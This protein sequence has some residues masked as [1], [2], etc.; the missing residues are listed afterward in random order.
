M[1]W[2]WTVA[3]GLI[4]AACVRPSIS[5][6][7]LARINGEP[8]T[9]EELNESFTSRH[10]GHGVLLAGRGA[11]RD[12][13]DTVIDR[14][15]L[16]QEALRIGA[17]EDPE[18]QR[19]RA[20]LRAKR[21]AEGFYADQVTKKVRVTDE[22]IAGVHQRLGDRFSARHILAE[23]RQDAARALERVRAGEEFGEVARQ[24][25]RADTASRGG[26]LGIVQWGRSEQKL[27]DVLWSLK[28][29]EISEPFETESG[30]NLL[31][32]VERT[33]VEPPKLAD[34]RQR[35]KANLEQRE[36]RERSTA[37]FRKLMKRPGGRIDEAPLVAALTARSG[38][39][40]PGATVVAEAAGEP[41]TLERALRLVKLEAAR[42][43]PPDRLRRQARWL[44]EAEVFRILLEKEG[45]ARGYG[46]RPMVVRELD[47]VTDQAAF[48]ALLGKVVLAKVEISDRDVS[49]YYRDHPK[50]YT[51]P[52]AVKLSA[53]LVEKE[54]EAK[55]LVSAL[56]QG[57]EFRVLARTAS[58]DPT[59]VASGGEIQGWI[60]RGKLDP[61]VEEVAF[62][63]KEGAVGIATGKAGHFVVRLDRRRAEQLKPFDEVKEHA[64]EAALR[65]RSRDTVKAWARKLRGASTI[66]VD[67][68]AIDRA[69]ASYEASAREK[70]AEKAERK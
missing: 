50:E 62:S 30:W 39:G 25:S 37:L 41:I 55:D 17:D 34:T 22:E 29:G 44:L 38:E 51:E 43:L 61:A 63:L 24:M 6:L 69:I 36:S 58:K 31:Y 70:A 20:T 28:K 48:Q 66:E 7:V 21:A 49:A 15:L 47:K 67:D 10:Q 3:L 56:A 13:L 23:S 53:I 2:V 1:R 33:S 45:L 59:L 5:D 60:T 9:V 54:D 27:E 57:K 42:A 52:E 46:D 4:L 11:V 68:A 8:I 40:P 19:A 18:I 64:R 16:I 26:D 12:F 65:Q 14:R 32:V 35:I